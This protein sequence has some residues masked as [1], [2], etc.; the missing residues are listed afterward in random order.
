M[1][2]PRWSARPRA[3]KDSL[4]QIEG[5]AR[6]DTRI[7]APITLDLPS[8]TLPL[9]GLI[10]SVPVTGTRAL[11]NIALE[12]GRYPEEGAHK[13]VVLLTKFAEARGIGVGDSVSVF[14]EEQRRTFEVVGQA[15]APEHLFSVT[16][17]DLTPEPGSF[18]VMWMR[19]D[20][21]APALGMTGAFNH[22]VLTLQPGTRAR[23]RGVRPRRCAGA[24]WRSGRF[25]AGQ[26]A[27][28]S[29]PRR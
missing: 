5:V 10:E 27:V 17:G 21:L 25:R 6:V 9:R 8:R 28:Q 29:V 11:S 2:S 7:V 12:K 19:R 18:A 26:A 20:A 3:W 24:L 16:P 23:P 13:E 22:V 1:C 4:S 15:T 14:V